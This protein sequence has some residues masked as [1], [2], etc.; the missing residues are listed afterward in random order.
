MESNLDRED[1]KSTVSGARQRHVGDPGQAVPHHIDDLRV[2]NITTQ[3]QFIGF[4]LR[5]HRTR[6]ELCFQREIDQLHPVVF[7]LDDPIP[8]DQNRDTTAQFHEKSR[9]ERR[10]SLP[11]QPDSEI[12]DPP[13]R[14]TVGGVDLLTG[15]AGEPEHGSSMATLDQKRRLIVVDGVAIRQENNGEYRPDEGD[16]GGDETADGHAI[17]ERR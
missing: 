16:T 6:W 5:A 3:Q 17:H 1:L 10:F 11:I 12:N 8:A 4:E 15:G 9:H 7:E 2:E 13:E 14:G